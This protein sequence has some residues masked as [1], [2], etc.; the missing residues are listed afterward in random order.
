MGTTLMD[1]PAAVLALQACQSH[2]R[3]PT[4]CSAARPQLAASWHAWLLQQEAPWALQ[5]SA[6]AQL[7]AVQ[8]GWL[9][10]GMLG[11]ARARR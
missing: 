9:H 11:V 3:W 6:D 4:A 10:C 5:V 2:L 8:H 1:T 7:S